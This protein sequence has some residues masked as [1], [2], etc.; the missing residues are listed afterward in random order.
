[1]EDDMAQIPYEEL[2]GILGYKWDDHDFVVLDPCVSSIAQIDL[3]ALQ[4]AIDIDEFFIEFQTIEGRRK[5]EI[6]WYGAIFP[7]FGELSSLAVVLD[8]PPDQGPGGGAGYLFFLAGS[9]TDD[10]RREVASFC[11]ELNLKIA[12]ALSKR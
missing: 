8:C 2:P 9:T 3:R 11:S 10:V 1:M 4:E 12:V 6:D 5:I 7:I